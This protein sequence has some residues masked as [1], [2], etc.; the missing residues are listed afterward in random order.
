MKRRIIKIRKIRTVK[1]HKSWNGFIKYAQK[2]AAALTFLTT[3]CIAV[4]NV[5]IRLIAYLFEYGKTL[6]FNVPNDAIDVSGNGIFYD[7]FVKGIV[8]VLFLL[9]NLLPYSLWKSEKKSVFLK[10]ILSALIVLLPN[11][12]FVPELI[13]DAYNGIVYPLESI[14][15]FLKT[16]TLAGFVVFFAGLLNGISDCYWKFKDKNKKQVIHLSK[17]QKISRIAV[18]LS[19]LIIVE[20]FLLIFA[21]YSHAASKKEFKIV[22]TNEDITYAVIYENSE[23]Y[24]ITECEIT[25]NQIKF[26][27]INTKQQIKKIDVEYTIIDTTQK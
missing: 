13:I 10:I 22:E 16:G 27:D 2:N 5:V 25:N 11:I 6:Y 26:P 23:N 20:S 15:S 19:I 4:G 21:G 14:L 9:L 1:K 12:L 7:F 24:I 3:S 8:A 18:I 17:R